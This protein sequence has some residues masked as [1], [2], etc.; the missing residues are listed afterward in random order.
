MG[1]REAFTEPGSWPCWFLNCC[2]NNQLVGAGGREK[3][4]GLAKKSKKELAG[5]SIGWLENIAM[6]KSLPQPALSVPVFGQ[7]LSRHGP[8]PKL[9]SRCGLALH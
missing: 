4:A 8:S 9:L 3:P 2:S 1:P 6:P 7:A 5:K